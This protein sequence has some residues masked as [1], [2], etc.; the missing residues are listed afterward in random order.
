V[1]EVF[2]PIF[3]WLL[4]PTVLGAIY[5][6]LL[7]ARAGSMSSEDARLGKQARQ[8][9]SFVTGQFGSEVLRVGVAI[10]T[11]A[12]VIG[13]VIGFVAGALVRLRDRGKTRRPWW[14]AALLHLAVI[15]GLHGLLVLWGMARTPQLYA[16]RWY[17]EGGL[18]RTVQIMATDVLGT[19]GV[20]ILAIVLVGLFLAPWRWR[21]RPFFRRRTAMLSAAGVLVVLAIA[22]WPSEPTIA[23]ASAPKEGRR[24]N[25]L[26]LSADSLR[27]DRINDR[28]APTLNA[29]TRKGTS[30]EKAYVSVPRTFPSWVTILTGR[31]AH[32]H[33][34]RSMFPRW[35]D[36]EKDLDTVAH[37]FARA[38]Y[39]TGVVSDFAGDVFGRADL[40]F[41]HDDTPAFDFRQLVRQ[42]AFE[43][44]T[45]LL[46]V[47]HSRL[48]R[49]FF[50]IMR[51]LNDAADP[52]MLSKDALH[53]LKK[54]EGR[55]FFLTVFYSTAHFPYSA[56]AP[57]YKKFTDPSYRGRFKY[58][59]P[60]GLGSE[61]PPD[62]ADIAQ[63]RGL[64][65]GAILSIDDAV[66]E[67][68][69]KLQGVLDNTIIV[70]TADHGETLH[71][72][73]HGQGHGDHLFGDEGTHVPLIVIDPR[74]PGGR[75]IT[76]VA[77]DVDIAPTLYE[78]T[79][80]APPQDLDGRS[81]V[82]ALEGKE[83][84][85]AFAYAESE[86]WFTEEIPAL[87]SDLRLP[88]PG[89]AGTSE[90]DA[91]HNDEIV[92]QK[93]MKAL[94][95]VA[96]HR[97]IRDERWKLLY[98]PTRTCV[99]YMLYDTVQDP[100]E[101]KLVDNKTEQERLKTELW[102]WM[103]RDPEMTERGGYLVPR[104]IGP[105]GGAHGLRLGDYKE[106]EEDE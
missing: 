27:F 30:F 7:A 70:V 5:V 61:A 42:R 3:R 16:D 46:P 97:M 79:G 81:L 77:R 71:D 57:Y 45:P 38:G 14:R 75:K 32:K 19:T 35:E 26:I 50:P 95:T 53:A 91:Q 67:L 74:R 62:A 54:N 52:S 8:F 4:R 104:A 20:V 55:P 13:G 78:L 39:F 102:K 85:P 92:L 51:E 94:T 64:Y 40:G 44:E 59:K 41:Q 31:H 100:G 98:V 90:I 83:L 15:A 37:R 60:V 49:F 73:G 25:V 23:V 10:V 47:L 28:T 66:K 48:G 84:A 29:L 63:I 2:A 105:L 103:L 11:S 72:H 76:R 106:E 69:A 82:P 101:T 18:L 80:V 9:S 17:A 36:R 6:V 34:V 43:R 96:R 22:L 1:R 21:I 65:D 33:G 89:I 86:L 24:P 58:K 93:S 12:I 68:L 87:P 88:Y 56:P 99:K